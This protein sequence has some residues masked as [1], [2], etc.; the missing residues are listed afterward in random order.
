MGNKMAYYGS[1]NIL[2]YAENDIDAG[3]ITRL[4]E[5]CDLHDMNIKSEFKL[6]QQK[7]SLLSRSRRETITLLH[8]Y[9]HDQRE[10]QSLA[11]VKGQDNEKVIA[12]K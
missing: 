7:K 6:V 2:D 8:M 11:K 10:K 5:K 12:T 1:K 9:V 4:I 3:D